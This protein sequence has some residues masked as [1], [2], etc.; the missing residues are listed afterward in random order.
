M[1]H[2]VITVL[3]QEYIVKLYVPQIGLS[4]KDTVKSAAMVQGSFGYFSTTEVK[5]SIYPC[6]EP[7]IGADAGC[8]LCTWKTLHKMLL[9]KR[10]CP[11][12]GKRSNCVR[13]QSLEPWHC[14]D[15]RPSAAGR[16]D[17][18]P[19]AELQIRATQAGEY[20]HHGRAPP[21]RREPKTFPGNKDG[22]TTHHKSPL[23][24]S[25]I[26]KGHGKSFVQTWQ[27]TGQANKQEIALVLQKMVP[28]RYFMSQL[29]A[30]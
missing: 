12:F 9:P 13:S 28:I 8:L 3:E 30:P 2:Y 6:M 15:S 18:W 26:F 14:W 4:H 11:F 24:T 7:C 5:P 27:R 1:D 19:R 23:I 10:R 22:V 17:G 20:P 21:K 25:L 16:Q 29:E